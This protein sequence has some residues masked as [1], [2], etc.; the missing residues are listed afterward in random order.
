MPQSGTDFAAIFTST[1]TVMIKIYTAAWKWIFM[2]AF[3]ILAQTQPI[4]FQPIV[5]TGLTNPIDI[6]IPPNASPA[7]GS[8]RIFVAQQNGLIRLWNGSSLSDF[9]NIDTLITTGG[10]RGLLSMTFHPGYNGTSNRDFF[11]FY[12]GGGGDLVVARFRTQPGNPTAVEINS[13]IKVIDSI[14]HSTFS[15]HNGGDLN[16]G[17]DGYLYLTTGDGGGGGDPLDNAQ[18]PLSLLGKLLR[19]DVT[20]AY[21]TVPQVVDIGLRNPFRWSFDKLTGDAWI[22]DVGQGS[23]E[24]IS[25][26]PV[27]SSGLNFGWDCYEGNMSY[28]PADCPA[29]GYTFPSYVY[30]NPTAGRSV[31]GGYVYRGSEYPTLYGYY[32]AVDYYSGR[33][34]RR[35]PAGTWAAQTTGLTTNIASFGEAPDGTLYAVSQFPNHDLYKVT[36][37]GVLPVVLTQFSGKRTGNVTEIKWATSY[38]Q[39]TAQFRIEWSKTPS[40]FQTAGVVAASRNAAGSH[41]TFPHTISSTEDLYYRLAILD[42][43]GSVSYSSIIRLSSADKGGIRIYP[44]VIKNNNLT[45]ELSKPALQMQLVSS[46]GSVVFQKDLRNVSG[47]TVIQLPPVAK[48]LYFVQVVVDGEVKREKLVIE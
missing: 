26:K 20:A 31:V 25:F 10:E 37:T 27:G 48:G 17:P 30:S 1:L 39:N 32:L 45:L 38:E 42:D 5:I 33:I 7:N 41:Y 28:E 36:L 29:S 23:W 43:D 13:G 8:T 11:L 24:E 19:I 9:F 4:T 3:P 34:F 16:F 35:S 6:A 40:N 46:A 21:P 2:L 47:T 14:D 15:N 18:N 12:T 44:T 22:G